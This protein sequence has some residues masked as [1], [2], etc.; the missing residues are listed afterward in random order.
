M[1][2]IPHKE[3]YQYITK[4]TKNYYQ[5]IMEDENIEVDFFKSFPYAFLKVFFKNDLDNE[6]ISTALNDLGSRDYGIDAYYC[7]DEKK[8]I[9]FFQFKTTQIYDSKCYKREDIEDFSGL[10]NR[11]NNTNHSHKNN[12]VK[13]IIEEVQS[14]DKKNYKKILY[15]VY[16]SNYKD[17]ELEKYKTENMYFY[18]LEEIYNNFKEYENLEKDTS[19][20]SCTIEF[21]D[22]HKNQKYPEEEGDHNYNKKSSLY[23]APYSQKDICIG[24][25][26][27]E[28]IINLMKKHSYS[29]FD[30]N[31]RYFLGSNKVNK[32]I[33]ETAKDNPKDFF[34]YNNGITITCEEFTPEGRSKIKLKKPQVINGGQTLNSIYE[35]YKNDS[36]NHKLKNLLLLTTIIKT[37]KDDLLKFTKDLTEYRNTNNP[38]KFSDYKGN[39]KDQEKLQKLFYEENYFYEIK[40][41]EYDRYVKYRSHHK[42]E[43]HNTIKNYE[44]KDKFK[45]Q[46]I[47]IEN[48]AKIWCAYKVQTPHIAKNFPKSIFSN[49]DT[50]QK[51]FP[52]DLNT[53]TKST[54]K[55]MIFAINIYKKLVY[56][57]KLSNKIFTNKEFSQEEEEIINNVFSQYYTNYKDNKTQEN[58][59][60]LAKQIEYLNNAKL[61]IL[62]LIKYIIDIKKH[63]SID[64]YYKSDASLNSLTKWIF[65]ILRLIKKVDEANNKNKPQ[66]FYN[67]AKSDRLYKNMK[68]EFKQYDN[69][70][71]EKFILK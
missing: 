61:H 9:R 16:T 28:F 25:I 27:G 31:V 65:H 4:H 62:A 36:N 21:I 34:Y 55:E 10:I 7:D 38:V 69:Y 33:Q 22:T 12:R 29:L 37:T 70:D 35:T 43:I 24:V 66:S 6:D 2:H 64:N 56:I 32:K 17:E 19:P 51:V 71:L 23:Y 18:N 46:K 50:Y 68:E 60:N 58:I 11:L 48:L 39:S 30:R 45:T 67:Y 5:N 44:Y 57:D 41:G 49:D 40:R 26:N 14:E 8:E 63:T 1:T 52:S 3:Q 59:D 13:S 20:E 53:Y 42:D 54:I 15:F 47:T